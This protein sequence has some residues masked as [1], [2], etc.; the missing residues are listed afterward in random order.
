[1]VHVAYSV[2][3]GNIRIQYNHTVGLACLYVIANAQSICELLWS[4]FQRLK[5]N[6]HDSTNEEEHSTGNMCSIQQQNHTWTHAQTWHYA[7]EL[8]AY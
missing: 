3:S 2:V 4:W 1:M 7:Y 8:I 6:G 5:L